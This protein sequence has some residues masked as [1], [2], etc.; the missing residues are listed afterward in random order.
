MVSLNEEVIRK[1]IAEVLAEMVPS[2]EA[3]KK[4]ESPSSPKAASSMKLAE[5][6][7]AGKSSDPRDVVIGISPGFGVGFNETIVGTP[8][9]EVLRQLMAGIEE[10]GMKPRVVRV[11]HTCDVAFIGKKAAELSGS[12]VAVGV[13]SRGTAVIHH[14]DLPPLG[15]LEL[16]PQ[17][18][19]L[20]SE[21][22][23]AIGRNAAKYGKGE[24]PVPVP[25]KND[26]MARPRYQGL[27]ALL[28]N[29]E[30]RFV[31]PKKDPVEIEVVF[32]R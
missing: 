28:H 4:A 8:H 22:F 24:N 23:R 16:F 10:E 17:S 3:G 7:A 32:E 31:D 14:K 1:V 25:T 13:L 5:K 2:P 19:L 27:A 26:P 18:P 30:M 15:N 29:K 12:G 9:S 20:D 21:T 11:L 6:G